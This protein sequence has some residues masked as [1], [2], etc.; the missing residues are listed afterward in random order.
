MR[1]LGFAGLLAVGHWFGVVSGAL[2]L[3][4]FVT[5]VGLLGLWLM[6]D[7]DDKAADA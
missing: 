4:P 6:Y 1:L 7:R 3:E 2:E 5:F